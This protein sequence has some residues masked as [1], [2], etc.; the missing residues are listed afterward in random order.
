MNE[1]AP[2]HQ[3]DRSERK[4]RTRRALLDAALELVGEHGMAGLGLREV[5]R[6]A[7]IVPG[8]FYRHFRTLEE[9][10]LALVEES[11]ESLHG[12]LREA[13]ANMAATGDVLEGSVDVLVAHV[14]AHR[15]HLRFIARERVGGVPTIRQAIRLEI[16]LFTSEL[17]TD[18]ARLPV[19]S[20]WATDDIN[21]LAEL[22]VQTIV[23]AVEA[24]LDV[25]P[26]RPEQV[27][28]VARQ[29]VRQV[30]LIVVG[31]AGWRSRASGG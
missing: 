19:V 23:H 27:E 4:E 18:L 2:E 30:R 15:A 20:S 22:I 5:C 24:L 3:L 16:R 14:A 21:L 26:G 6:H 9:L 25:P 29:V 8:A 17:A 12:L 10:G 1:R 31:V 28:A 11:F 7:G 13:R